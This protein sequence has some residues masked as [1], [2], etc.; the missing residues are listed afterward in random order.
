MHER[1][2]REMVRR[3]ASRRHEIQISAPGGKGRLD[4]DH[5]RL[6]DADRPDAD[7]LRRQRTAAPAQTKA[8]ERGV[9][10]APFLLLRMRKGRSR[11]ER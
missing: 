6:I 1:L 10:V 7:E 4:L 5:D 2:P 11:N 9:G 3:D 8:I